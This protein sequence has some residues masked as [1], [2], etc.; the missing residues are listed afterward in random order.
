MNS[1]CLIFCFFCL[2][3][4]GACNE[5]TPIPKPKAQIRLEYPQGKLATLETANFI[6]NYNNLANPKEN[7]DLAYT[8]EYPDMKVAHFLSHR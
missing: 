2:L 4:L 7:K 8:L 6:I 3:V 5:Q 1:N